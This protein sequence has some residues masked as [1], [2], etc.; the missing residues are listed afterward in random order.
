[1]SIKKLSITAICILT[2]TLTLC[3]CESNE[4]TTNSTNT[5]AK[6]PKTEYT[7]GV[8]QGGQSAYYDQILTGFTT[9]V[10][11]NFQEEKVVI[12]TVIA[13]E[14]IPTDA[15]CQSFSQNN[16][17]LIF[18]IGENSLTSAHNATTT[19]PIVGTA[20][21]DFQKAL[22]IPADKDWD[23]KSGQ[24]I[25]GIS[26]A[27]NMADILSMMIEVTP[28]INSVGILY[29]PEDK[30]SEYQNHIL[31]KYLD[32]AG[33]KWKEYEFYSPSMS[34]HAVREIVDFAASESSV[35]FIPAESK[36]IEK[37]GVIRNAAFEH[38]TPTVAGD[39]YIGEDTLVS[40]YDDPYDQ[41]YKAGE[42]AYDILKSGKRPQNMAIASPSTTAEQKLYAGDIAEKMDYKFPKSFKERNDFL[43]TYKI[44]SKTK[45]DNQQTK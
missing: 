2:L 28:N 44:G 30:D 32:Q 45:R 6:E 7:I 16:V 3:G 38:S 40:M 14:G 9:A 17:S 1:M 33:I 41:G 43:S 4:N 35:L 13:D 36:L 5:T 29:C 15:I 31:E 21:M 25:T 10:N 24:N 18:S 34:D 11:D 8:C 26:S 20:V 19:I 42:M 39:E 22:N 12:N 37:M 27:P 23:K